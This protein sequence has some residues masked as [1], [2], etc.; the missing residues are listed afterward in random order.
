LAAQTNPQREQGPRVPKVVLLEQL[1]HLYV[2][3]LEWFFNSAA[4]LARRVSLAGK[5]HPGIRYE[6]TWLWT[7]L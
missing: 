1:Y 5:D 4:S 6:P 7:T 2:V 3:V